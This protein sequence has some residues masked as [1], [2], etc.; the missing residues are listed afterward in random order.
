MR[1]SLL[2]LAIFSLLGASRS[3]ADSCEDLQPLRSQLE[4]AL[5]FPG[6]PDDCVRNFDEYGECT[7]EQRAQVLQDQRQQEALR[8][9]IEVLENK[10]PVE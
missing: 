1:K 6:V 3:F 9:R 4:E 8:V 10:C 7:V 2:V 5:R